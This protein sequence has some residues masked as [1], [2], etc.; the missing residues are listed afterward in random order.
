MCL[1]TTTSYDNCLAVR[2]HLD[3]CTSHIEHTR[4]QLDNAPCPNFQKVHQHVRNTSRCYCK[5]GAS[6][7]R[8]AGFAV[9][10]GCARMASK[11]YGENGLT[12]SF[13]KGPDLKLKGKKERAREKAKEKEVEV[14]MEEEE[15]DDVMKSWAGFK[16]AGGFGGANGRSASSGTAEDAI[17]RNQMMKGQDYQQAKKVKV[18]NGSGN[19]P[20]APLEPFK[21]RGF[22]GDHEMN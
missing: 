21:P 22:D 11:G 15:D 14:K 3:V 12:W 7:D 1:Q 10:V 4:L 2:V 20:C 17:R 19:S 6:L 9:G 16:A 5:D 8:E 18:E 13:E